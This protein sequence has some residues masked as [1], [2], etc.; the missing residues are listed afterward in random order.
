[1]AEEKGAQTAIEDPRNHDLW[2]WLNGALVKRA[3]ALVSIFD[4]GFGLGDGV[5]E[6]IRMAKGRLVL[7]DDHLDRLYEGANTIALDIGLT[8]PQMKAALE[9]LCAANAITDGG[10]IRLMVTRGEKHTVHQDPRNAL[11]RPTIAITAEFKL[12]DPEIKK[13]G[14]KL[15]TS[16]FRTSG[17]DSFDLHLNSHS[18]LNFI[19]PLLQ[20]IAAGAHEALML[21][22]A[23]FVASCNS[24]N[25][26][27]VKRGEVLTSTGRT[28]FKGITRR[29]VIELCGKEGIACRETDFTLAEVYNADGAFVTGTFGGITP[30]R[31]LDGRSIGAALPCPLTQRLSDLYDRTF[32]N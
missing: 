14:I 5:W 25:F 2:I 18:R 3:E 28:C 21:D 11:G 22:P 9:E 20:A 16:S 12:P 24:T 23:G 8:K 13:S 7:V 10:H 32:L 31:S 19:R 4:A 6:G 30:V 27:I 1:M 15:F 17:P 29:K 26:F